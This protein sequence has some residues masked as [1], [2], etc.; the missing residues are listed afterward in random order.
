MLTR[1]DIK[2][3]ETQFGNWIAGTPIPEEQKV[4][5]W[6][7]GDLAQIDNIVSEDSLILY[8]EN[9][10][11][12]CKQNAARSGTEQWAD[13][14][15]VFPMMQKLQRTISVSDVPVELHPLKCLI[16]EQLQNLADEG[17]L[18]LKPSKK[19]AIID[20]VA[21]TPEM[22]AKSATRNGILHGGLENGMI[23]RNT[24]SYPDFDVMLATCKLDPT[25]E[26]YKLCIDSFPYL[27]KSYLEN[28]HV[29]D[30]VFERLGFPMDK[31]VDGLEVSNYKFV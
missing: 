12:A 5:S 31:D 14:T 29:E 20:F 28:G 6:C 2:S 19:H 23:D 3:T 30:E 25:D 8:Q 22:T 27:F 1:R 26:E 17:R 9:L 4:V 18:K 13:L 11:C 15:K 16:T 24:K 7:D 10:I 21:S